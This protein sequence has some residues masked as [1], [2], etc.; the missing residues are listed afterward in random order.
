MVPV[1]AFT[2]SPAT[3]RS[4]I[5]RLLT[6]ASPM[7]GARMWINQL[8]VPPSGS[9]LSGGGSRQGHGQPQKDLWGLHEAHT[10]AGRGGKEGLGLGD[11]YVGGALGSHHR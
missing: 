11:R 9:H 3:P 4:M 7:L 6:W 8:H 2:L 1:V 10:R 5:E